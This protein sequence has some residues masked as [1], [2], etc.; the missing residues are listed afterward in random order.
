[1]GLRRR[2]E[3]GNKRKKNK[4]AQS[5]TETKQNIGFL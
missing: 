5:T 2:V 4:S 3:L 1:M